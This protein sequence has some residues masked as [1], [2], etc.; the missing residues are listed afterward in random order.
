MEEE[1]IVNAWK[2]AKKRVWQAGG[3]G[4]G[5]KVKYEEVME[6]LRR[7]A[8]VRGSRGMVKMWEEESL[9]TKMTPDRAFT[10]LDVP[11]DVDESML[12]AIFSMRVSVV[13]FSC[14]S[15]MAE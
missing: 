1:F 13:L 2:D 7:V 5:G 9:G 15:W 4:G 14:L 8:E 11:Q 10:T 12:I 3:V 6:A